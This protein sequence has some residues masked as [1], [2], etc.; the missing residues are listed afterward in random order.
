MVSLYSINQSFNQSINQL[1]IFIVPHIES[2]S[3]ALCSDD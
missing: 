1:Q 2:E 3:E